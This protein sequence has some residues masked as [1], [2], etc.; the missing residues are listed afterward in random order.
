MRADELIPAVLE[1]IRQR[2]K[3]YRQNHRYW[4]LQ[5]VALGIVVA[6]ALQMQGKGARTLAE[7]FAPVLV[8]SGGEQFQPMNRTLYAAFATL[9]SKSKKKPAPPFD[10]DLSEL[11]DLQCTV[12]AKCPYYLNLDTSAYG[13][14]PDDP[15]QYV[16]LEK[17]KV[18][19]TPPTVYYH[20]LGY[21]AAQ[22]ERPQAYVVE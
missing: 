2:H 8:L 7:T 9:E 1:R 17:D 3:T 11:L 13:K 18:D 20:V 15:R 14:H 5:H 21:S 19:G 16:A 10:H 6:C 22:G 4:I 12:G